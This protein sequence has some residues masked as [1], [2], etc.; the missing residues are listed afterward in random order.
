[1]S[2]Q[3]THTQSSNILPLAHLRYTCPLILVVAAIVQVIP[4][5][6]VAS[7][8]LQ[9]I[10][11]RAREGGQKKHRAKQKWPSKTHSVTYVP[12]RSTLS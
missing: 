1:M 7:T 6:L 5:A 4:T 10:T 3:I 11:T 9:V 2:S 12:G 8:P